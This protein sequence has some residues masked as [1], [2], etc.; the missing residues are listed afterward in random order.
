LDR[1]KYINDTLGHVIGDQL[2]K[3]ISERLL[4]NMNA[5]RNFAARMGGDE[6]IN[7]FRCLSQ[8]LKM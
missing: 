7:G 6:F 8:T 3:L 2:L 5:E 1:F 4:E